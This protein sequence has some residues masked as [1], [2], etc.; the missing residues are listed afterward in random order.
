MKISRSPRSF[1]TRAILIAS[2]FLAQSALA[3]PPSIGGAATIP[4]PNVGGSVNVNLRQLGVL[5]GSAPLVLESAQMLVNGQTTAT[6][7]AS[8][9]KSGGPGAVCVTIRNADFTIGPAGAAANV[10]SL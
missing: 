3:A 10:V 9:L 6:L 1:V 5:S 2:A 4:I 7:V 8:V